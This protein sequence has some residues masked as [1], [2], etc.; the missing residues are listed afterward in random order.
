MKSRFEQ[1]GIPNPGS[2]EARKRG[3]ICA[4]IDNHYG[5]GIVVDKDPVFWITAGCPVH[6][7]RTVTT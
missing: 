4:V 1:R 3:C 5:A 7:P 6:A 2:E